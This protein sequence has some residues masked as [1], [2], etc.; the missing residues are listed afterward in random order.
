VQYQP[1]SYGVVYL[2]A[3]A[4][5]LAAGAFVWRRRSTP[6][7]LWLC[8]LLLAVAERA[9]ADA[10]DVSAVGLQTKVFWGKVSWIGSATIGSS[11]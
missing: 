4:I 3:T 6:G 7:A 8:L 11:C 9:F 10:L 2:A 1:S 5:A